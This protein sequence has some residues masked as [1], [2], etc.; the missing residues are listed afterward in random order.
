VTPTITIVGLGPG[1]TDLLTNGTITAIAAHEAKWLRTRV[2]P[3]ASALG[4]A[5]SFDHLYETL[6]SFDA[7][8]ASIVEQLVASAERS[9]AGRVLY[10]VPGSPMVAE[11]TVEMLVADSRVSVVIV[12]ALSYLDLTWARLRIDP[13]A[14]GVRVVDGLRFEQ[15]T[16]G[17]RGP[18][19]V[20]QCHS[21]AVLSDIK[22]TPIDPPERVIVLQRLGLPDESIR[23]IAWDDL[24]RLIEPDHLTSL[25]IPTMPTP[26][27]S[28]MARVVGVM[29]RLN[30]EC[31]WYAQ[32][33]H[34]SL[35][36]YAIEEAYELAEAIAEDSTDDATDT[37]TDHLVEELGDLLF[38]AVFHACL[39]TEDGRFSL[40]DV[41]RVVSDKLV[42]RNPHVFGG[43]AVVDADE[44]IRNWEAI[45]AVERGDAAVTDGV[46]VDPMAGLT[47][48][49]PS[50]TYAAKV[51]MRAKAAGFAVESAVLPTSVNAGDYL[52]S[53]VAAIKANDQD[54]ELELRLAAARYRDQVREQVRERST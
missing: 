1:D 38:Q 46:A 50:L 11:R 44:V 36:P 48:S 51:V 24:D 33:T 49:L 43:L 20:S 14:S 53:V 16:D 6:D 27:R 18:L 13:H 4:D 42:R 10:A 52:L 7:V 45:K 35:A 37:H 21:L 34:M 54:P 22:C 26:L 29:A 12:P 32:Q 23:D 47:E 9:P 3:A 39:G 2:H 28:E 40:A 30:A 41:A 8:Y 25:W 5:P 31:P 19:L 17:E 15:E